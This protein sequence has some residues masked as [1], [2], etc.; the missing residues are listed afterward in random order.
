MAPAVTVITLRDLA[1]LSAALADGMDLARVSSERIQDDTV[2]LVNS[3]IA[4]NKYTVPVLR[5]RQAQ[6]DRWLVESASVA[7]AVQFG[8]LL[9]RKLADR[10]AK[11]HFILKPTLATGWGEP[12]EDPNAPLDDASA[13]LVEIAS[14]IAPFSYALAANG[15]EAPGHPS[16]FETTPATVA[17]HPVR[18]VG[19]RLAV[20]PNDDLV[21][22]DSS[23]VDMK[24]LEAL[25]TGVFFP[26]MQRWREEN[27]GK[28]PDLSRAYLIDA[29]LTGAR[30]ERVRL[31]EAD[32]RG[33]VL[34]AASLSG[35]DLSQARLDGV[36]AARADLSMLDGRQS[37]FSRADLTEA[38]LSESLFD[39]ATFVGAQLTKANLTGTSLLKA[40]LTDANLAG[41]NLAGANLAGGWLMRADLRG[42]N[43]AGA[44]LRG[45]ILRRANLAGA[46]L[47]GADLSEAELMDA[48]LDSANLS[49][50][51]LTRADL[52]QATLRG[53]VL[54]RASLIHA[55]L[56][57]ADLTG[58][59]LTGSQVYGVSA[60]D[61]TLADAEQS[62][63]VIN[64][65]EPQIRVDDLEVAQ[66]IYL[67]LNRRKLRNVLT[68]IGER[69]VLVL[70]R[71]TE[72]KELLDGIADRLRTLGYLPIIFDFER[73]TNLDL[74]E[75]IRTL[76]GLSLFV[77]ADITNPRS[78]PLE[79][80]AT[81]P[82]YMVPFVSMVERNHPVFGMFDDLPA[83]YDWALPL[84]EYSSRESL[85]TAFEAKVVQPALLKVEEIRRR[86]AARPIRRSA[87]D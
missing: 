77:I 65:A 18:F 40:Q 35:S 34:T 44:Y 25:R 72:R 59:R 13:L 73:P 75:T 19:W 52:F 15:T 67:L 82:D 47:A 49:D 51:S 76:A 5:W 31:A 69:A 1:A 2:R 39:G 28:D 17:G 61:L 27:P 8:V 29:D 24:H 4:G 78:V 12:P 20:L 64:K 16:W 63:L 74:T 87:E 83:K 10:V 80:Q 42:A 79:L 36:R 21:V 9:L 71:F 68:T 46:N 43:L 57:S 86:K 38:T 7:E 70:G 33:A 45:A 22:W 23:G 50:A 37:S 84:L 62:D 60:W 55:I 81:V 56:V 48:N 66:F 30:L 54:T 6:D 14:S 85:M 3:A 11:G 58:A 53:A 32:L 26:A 41:A